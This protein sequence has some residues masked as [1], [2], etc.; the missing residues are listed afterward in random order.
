MKKLKLTDFIAIKPE[1][2]VAKKKRTFAIRPPTLADQVW[3]SD[4]YGSLEVVTEIMSKRNWR[5]VCKVVYFLLSSKDRAAFPA[6]HVVL[7]NENGQKTKK[8]LTGPEI[9]LESLSGVAEATEMMKALTRAICLSNPE[10][11]AIVQADVKKKMDEI[12]SRLGK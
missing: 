10:V 6:Q 1:F 5:E 11:D 9:L 12:N 3:F 2:T 8:F 7:V 4:S